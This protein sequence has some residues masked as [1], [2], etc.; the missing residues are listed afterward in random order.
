MINCPFVFP[1]HIDF[2]A[3]FIRGEQIVVLL[4]M[5]TKHSGLGL[6]YTAWILVSGKPIVVCLTQ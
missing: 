4:K 6:H 5:Y 1:T 3:G 2:L